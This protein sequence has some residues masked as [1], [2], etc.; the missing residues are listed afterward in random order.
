V[1][2]ISEGTVKHHIQTLFR[3]LKPADREELGT[4]FEQALAPLPPTF[5]HS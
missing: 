4:L 2:H 1:L 5:G 3:K